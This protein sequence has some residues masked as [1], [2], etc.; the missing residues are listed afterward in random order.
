MKKLIPILLTLIGFLA[1][2]EK[3]FASIPDSIFNR[4]VKQALI[5]PQEKIYLHTDR[6]SYIAGESIW[7]RAYVVDGITHAPTQLSR[8]VYVTLQNPFLEKIVQVK[9][10]ADSVGAIH[11]NLELPEDLPKGE[12]YLSAHTQ[13][14]RNFDQEYFFKKRITINSMMS[15]GIR[16]ETSLKGRDLYVSFF[17][18]VTG[19]AKEVKNCM[20]KAASNTIS[21]L[22]EGN[23][24]KIKL[25]NS[26]EKVV[27][28]QAGNYKEFVYVNPEKD[29]DVSFLPEGGNLVYGN[30]NRMAFKCV[31][32]LG[33]GEDITGSLRDEND[34]I[35]LTFQS[36]HRGMGVFSFIPQKDRTYTAVCQTTDGKEK[37][38]QL[39]ASVN[40]Y[41]IQVN[42]VRDKY[43]VKVLTG[44]GNLTDSLYILAH[45]KGW[46]VMIHQCNPNYNVYTFNAE[47][48]TQG[49]VSFLLFNAQ[50]KLLNERMV[51]LDKREAPKTVL[52]S[53]P[54]EYT[55][56][57]KVCLTLDVSDIK[58]KAWSGDCSIAITDNKDV[59]PDSC[60]NI[61]STLLLESDLR[62]HIEEPAW[63]FRPGNEDERKQAL[64]ILMMTQGW[65]KYD[66][67]QSWSSCFK[68]PEH[69]F[70]QSMSLTGKVTTR[71]SRK[72]IEDI[73]VRMMVPLQ[74]GNYE[75][76]T[77][78]DGEFRF[79][80]FEYPDST[81][82]WVSAYDKKGK[83][84]V[85]VKLDSVVH[86]V[87]QRPLP[88]FNHNRM[89]NLPQQTQELISKVSMMQL[90][91]GGIRHYFMD[92]VLVTAQ[93]KKPKTIYEKAI[94][95]KTVR[96]ETIR[97][98]G[99]QDVFLLVQQHVAGVSY[100]QDEDGFYH[101]TIRGAKAQLVIDDVLCY[102]KGAGNM[103]ATFNK[104]DIEQIDVL[105]PPFS[106]FFDPRFGNGAV[107][108]TTKRGGENHNAKWIKTNL[109]R[110]MPLG[111]Q[112]ATEFYAPKYDFTTEKENKVPDLRTT[113]YWNP[114]IRVKEGKADFEFYTADGLIDYSIVIEGVSDDGRLLRVEKEIK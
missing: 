94:G 52:T 92:E 62:G 69:P 78:A 37:R 45:Q 50:G 49:I 114:A 73:K 82:Y 63:Y 105:K 19:E 64:D 20:A 40:Q 103:I 53:L 3:S 71:I 34:S 68:T 75:L 48:F 74:G 65:R 81:Q 30:F 38:F 72:G 97:Q 15:K 23:G 4:T 21:T 51:F 98:S 95:A 44:A 77:N 76:T 109:K 113:I 47:N 25:Y 8:Y 31:N 28:V 84:N 61:L 12:Y 16:L 46:P 112:E 1:K 111:F 70:E 58:G 22:H 26:E 5:L 9:L 56:R 80:G 79:D 85:V 42:E 89:N 29:Y 39:P 66:L 106:G 36:T 102:D 14:M 17:D 33:Q 10:R 59:I 2:E 110:S 88:P 27:L 96:E 55:Q 101:F 41:S 54:N 18:P 90:H 60:T 57:E 104:N 7:M 93:K 108:I 87:L 32:N 13:Y 35:L 43:Y 99:V 11:G 100:G 91:E 83:D 107:I 24:Y 6:D 67:E 86:P